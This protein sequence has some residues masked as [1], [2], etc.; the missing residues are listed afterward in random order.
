[1]VSPFAP[2]V[3]EELW[4]RLGHTA[5]LAREPYPVADP[6]LAKAEAV[7]CVVQIKGKV[8]HKVEVDPEID[9]AA[10]E[11]LVM[12][13]E[14]VQQLIDGQTVRKVIVKAPRVVNIVV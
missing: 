8:R 2:H 5:S 10:L 7:T 14:R 11:A 3:A 12:A 6:E 1:M 13:E 4:E 9:E